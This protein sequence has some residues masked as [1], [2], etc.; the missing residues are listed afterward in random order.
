MLFMINNFLRL[1]LTFTRPLKTLFMKK[2]IL[3]LFVSLFSY[4]SS[5]ASNASLVF[6]TEGSEPFYVFL[7]GIKQNANVGNNVKIFAL[8]EN[9]YNVLVVIPHPVFALVNYSVRITPQKESVYSIA[10]NLKGE[11]ELVPKGENQLSFTPS[12]P[13]QQIIKYVSNLASAAPMPLGV[14]AGMNVMTGNTGQ[15]ATTY[16][17]T[18]TTTVV[19]GNAGNSSPPEYLPGYHGPVGC[20]VPM[21]ARE[22]Q[23]AKTTINSKP[24]ESGKIIIAKQVAGSNC[25]F[26][27]QVKE[28]MDLF[29]FEGTKIEFAKFAY[30]HTYDKGNYFMVNDAFDFDSSV[31]ELNKFL[32]K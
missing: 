25:L 4:L 10:K 28:V 6:F 26:S 13:N 32:G 31:N 27:S 29:S 15:T 2:I 9:R 22:F 1:I 20:P 5:D 24:F 19:S 17:T 3:F 23:Q 16:S 18:T 12:S 11:Y 8:Q 7:N 21:P 30:G 14:G